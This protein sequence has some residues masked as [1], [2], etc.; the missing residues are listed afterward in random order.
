LVLGRHH[1]ER[2]GGP[3]SGRERVGV[4]ELRHGVARVAPLLGDARARVDGAAPTLAYER[5]PRALV[6]EE[7]VGRAALEAD[8][9][10]RRRH[11]G[12]RHVPF[13]DRGL[14]PEILETAASRRLLARMPV[15]VVR[16]L[17]WRGDGL[18]AVEQRPVGAL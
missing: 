11:A 1:A 16:V 12:I 17:Q 4:R 5:A 3:W 15:H 13:A 8:Q 2:T 7:R 10:V 18:E 9:D 6:G 14:R